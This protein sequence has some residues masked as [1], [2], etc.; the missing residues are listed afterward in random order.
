MLR[1]RG[2]APQK[3]AE[4]LAR[5]GVPREGAMQAGN[6]FRLPRVNSRLHFHPRPIFT[7]C[8]SGL[9]PSL[10]TLSLLIMTSALPCLP[11]KGGG[12]GGGQALAETP[13]DFPGGPMPVPPGHPTHP[14]RDTHCSWPG[15][16]GLAGR[17]EPSTSFPALPTQLGI[18]SPAGTRPLRAPPSGPCSLGLPRKAS[19]NCPFLFSSCLQAQ[20][21][22]CPPSLGVRGGSPLAAVGE[23]VQPRVCEHQ[24]W[25]ERGNSKRDGGTPSKEL[26]DGRVGPRPCFQD[27]WGLGS[28]HPG[29]PGPWASRPGPPRTSERSWAREGAG[30]PGLPC[31]AFRLHPSALHPPHLIRSAI[32]SPPLLGIQMVSTMAPPPPAWGRARA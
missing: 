22:L 3:P 1:A 19:V 27:S 18:A 28:P 5:Q 12:G 26:E 24:F 32:P 14:I 4:R 25:A 31:P 30:R 29:S 16:R 2:C 6:G 10:H 11:G 7:P 8:P 9:T 20:P 23:D 13:P 21:P 15:G 17:P